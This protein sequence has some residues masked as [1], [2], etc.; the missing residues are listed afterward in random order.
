MLYFPSQ[1]I[2]TSYP[3]LDAPDLKTDNDIQRALAN[4]GVKYTHRNEDLI[5]ENVFEVQRVKALKEVSSL[6]YDNLLVISY[7]YQVQ[8]KAFVKARFKDGAS[9]RRPEKQSIEPEWPPKRKHHK[10]L[11]AAQEKLISIIE[12][13]LDCTLTLN[14]GLCNVKRL[15]W[16]SE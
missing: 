12:S 10:A 9:K 6:S 1:K 2:Y 16:N 8:K 5:A 14:A 7:I 15:Y 13:S 11:P 4:I 3:H